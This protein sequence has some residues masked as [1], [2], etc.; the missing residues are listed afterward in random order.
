MLGLTVIGIYGLADPLRPEIVQSVIDC[1]KAG[2][3]IRMVTGDNLDT[4]K[5]IAIEA[6]ILTENEASSGEF[7]FA[8]MIGQDFRRMCGQLKK[9]TNDK[10]ELVKE[11]IE[12][13]T[14]FTEIA[15]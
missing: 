14:Q 13:V 5:A 1:H 7:P 10:G 6:G 2:I 8:F 15:K 11:E 3:T 9:E 4:A 12:N